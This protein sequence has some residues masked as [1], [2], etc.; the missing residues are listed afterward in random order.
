MEINQSQGITLYAFFEAI[1]QQTA[2]FPEDLQK[3]MTQ[4]AGF[5]PTEMNPTEINVFV[6][7]LADIAQHPSLQTFYSQTREQVQPD[8]ADNP[9]EFNSYLKIPNVINLPEGV[10]ENIIST[11]QSPD[12]TIAQ[13]TPSKWW[14]SFLP[15]KIKS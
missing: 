15:K 11:L 4:V 5:F 13:P 8:Y 10:S 9:E 12:R 1:N 7:K 6:N 2:P 14:K 3:Q